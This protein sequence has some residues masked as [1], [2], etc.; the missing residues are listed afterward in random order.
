MRSK[1]PSNTVSFS[2][3]KNRE[4]D[5]Y[6][7]K[8][9]NIVGKRLLQARNAIGWT[10]AELSEHLKDYGL[11]TTR[12][13]ISKWETGGAVPNAYQLIALC[14]ALGIDE[15]AAYFTSARHGEL[16]EEGMKKVHAYRTDLI[17]TGKYAPT[18]FAEENVIEY[19][20]MPLSYLPVSAGTGTF[21]SEGSFEIVSFPKASVPKGADFALRISGDSMEPVY[22][23]GQIV[24]VEECS[25]LHTGEEGI[26]IYDGNGYV[27]VL[28]EQS[29][30]E[31][32][33]ECFESG[34]GTIHTQPVLIS[35]NKN[36]EPIA[37][38]PLAEFR[39]IG[40]VL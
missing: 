17:A 33:R 31:N 18:P 30:N 4:Y 25:S 12:S 32:V 22:Q 35:Y 37:V 39:I 38:S 36:Y 26:F 10:L 1:K 19:I 29:P 21:L 20:D 16:N 23:D 11:T 24:W 5:A 14:K 15:G 34:D 2:D 7:E 13:S 6:A 27:K 28:G 40:R 9:Q 3:I 8:E